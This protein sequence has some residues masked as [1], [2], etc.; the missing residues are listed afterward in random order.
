MTTKSVSRYVLHSNIQFC[1]GNCI[2]Y[3]ILMIKCVYVSIRYNRDIA[4]SIAN[5]NKYNV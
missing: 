4:N 2:K 1:T 3:K 5:Q